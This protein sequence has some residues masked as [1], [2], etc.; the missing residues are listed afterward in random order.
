LTYYLDCLELP[1]SSLN[2]TIDFSIS[3]YGGVG[4]ATKKTRILLVKTGTARK[5]DKIIPGV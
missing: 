1:M 5:N 3:H 4:Q 2:L